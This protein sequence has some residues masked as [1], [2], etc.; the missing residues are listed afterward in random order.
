MQER[1][2]RRLHVFIDEAN[3]MGAARSAGKLIDWWQLREFLLGSAY[4]PDFSE[5]VVYVGLPPDTPEWGVARRKK[6]SF[7]HWLKRNGFLVV[8]KDGTPTENGRS[9]KCNLDVVMAVDSFSRALM[10]QP[11]AVTL[12]TGDS[13]FSHL[14]EL[15]RQRGIRVNVAAVES[16]LGADLRLAATHVEDLTRFFNHM[17][18]SLSSER[19]QIRGGDVDRS[20]PRGPVE[21]ADSR[22]IWQQLD[23]DAE[24]RL[25]QKL[26]LLR[27]RLRSLDLP[28]LVSSVVDVLLSERDA[29]SL[30]E[31]SMLKVFRISSILEK[32]LNVSVRRDQDDATKS[33]I[34]TVISGSD[35]STQMLRIDEKA[36]KHLKFS[37]L[38]RELWD[39]WE[40][41]Q[42]PFMVRIGGEE[43]VAGT[44]AALATQLESVNFG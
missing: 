43:F 9:Y 13:D 27:S 1:L 12:V 28:P 23:W 5:F 4:D 16:M 44:W 37:K 19:G 7:I 29:L 17:K 21:I 38:H 34:L 32:T 24:R 42:F 22:G 2:R 25:Q 40:F 26:V 6:E 10:A 35:G 15:I 14:A 30:G 20:V 11:D 3:L 39:G 18:E 31:E 8:T 36:L 33:Y 41:G